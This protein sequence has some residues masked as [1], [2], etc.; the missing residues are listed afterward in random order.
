MPNPPGRPINHARRAA[1]RSAISAPGAT[2][3]E[4]ALA[5][6]ATRGTVRKIRDEAGIA[7][8]PKGKRKKK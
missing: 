2:V 5:F 4:V 8:A 3:S 1:I 7:P 6:G